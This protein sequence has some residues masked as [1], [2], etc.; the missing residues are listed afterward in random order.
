MFRTSV[1]VC[2]LCF[3]FVIFLN[4]NATI[5]ERGGFTG[6]PRW[7]WL[8][9]V[10]Q[11]SDTPPKSNEYPMKI[12]DWFK[13][14]ISWIDFRSLFRGWIRS[15]S[16]GGG[17]T[18]PCDTP[19]HFTLEKKNPSPFT[20]KFPDEKK[21][22]CLEELVDEVSW[23]SCCVTHRPTERSSADFIPHSLEMLHKPEVKRLVHLKIKKGSPPTFLFFS[24]GIGTRKILFD[25]EGFGFN[26]TGKGDFHRTWKASLSWVIPL[27][28]MPV[29]HF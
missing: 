22:V 29:T 20:V 2:F 19:Y 8:S 16:G 23:P 1:F 6:L 17:S 10:I 26:P 3:A 18:V 5:W 4:K 12:N 7:L 9:N 14:F 15:F 28:R 21:T 27:P 11:N 13:W 24:D 25:R